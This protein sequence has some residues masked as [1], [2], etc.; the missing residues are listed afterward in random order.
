MVRQGALTAQGERTGA[1]HHVGLA[2]TALRARPGRALSHTAS[3]A[4]PGLTVMADAPET[5][6]SD[7]T[8]NAPVRKKHNPQTTVHS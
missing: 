5:C 3:W 6:N 4:G 7:Q 1:T 8:S 2:R